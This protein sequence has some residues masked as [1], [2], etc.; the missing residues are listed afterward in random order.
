LIEN[1]LLSSE[2]TATVDQLVDISKKNITD[3]LAEA[4]S[5]QQVSTLALERVR[6]DTDHIL[7]A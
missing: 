2:L 3:S 1:S 5:A 6:I 4:T 7:H